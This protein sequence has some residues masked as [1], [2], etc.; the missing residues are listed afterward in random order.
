MI[1]DQ[2]LAILLSIYAGAA[3]AT[4]FAVPWGEKLRFFLMS[5]VYLA[6]IL[7]LASEFPQST[8]WLFLG[9]IA[10]L[11]YFA[12]RTAPTDDDRVLDNH[13]PNA[14][15]FCSECGKRREL[16][17]ARYCPECAHRYPDHHDSP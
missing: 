11:W 10:L 13:A 1:S 6:G 7:L 15:R 16:P 5:I 8:L 17:N 12:A 2:A 3:I 9:G 14:V 4:I